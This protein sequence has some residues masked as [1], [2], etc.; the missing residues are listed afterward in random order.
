[1]FIINYS[2]LTKVLYDVIT[3]YLNYIYKLLS[4]LNSEYNIFIFILSWSNKPNN[5]DLINSTYYK[6]VMIKY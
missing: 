6:S 4:T 2:D 5:V 1:M 3:F